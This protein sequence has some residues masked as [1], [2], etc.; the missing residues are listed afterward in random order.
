MSEIG[1]QHTYFPDFRL[2]VTQLKEIAML[3]PCANSL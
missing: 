1:G 3:C 2:A